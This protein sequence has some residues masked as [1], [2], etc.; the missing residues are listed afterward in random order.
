MHCAGETAR[1]L[2]TVRIA[3][4]GHPDGA[5]VHMPDGPTVHVGFRE[6]QTFPDELAR[7]L[8][9]QGEDQWRL[10][11]HYGDQP[12]LEQRVGV[13]P[14]LLAGWALACYRLQ[15]GWSQ[16]ELA[17]RLS[18]AGC[19]LDQ[20]AVSRLEA[21]ERGLSVDELITAA[22]ELNVSP[23]RLLEGAPLPT[24]PAVT[25]TDTVTVPGSRYRTWLRGSTPLPARKEWSKRTGLP[26]TNAYRQ[27]VADEDWLQ[28]QRHTIELLTRAGQEIINA[29]IQIRD[30]LTDESRTSLAD[31]T[32]HYHSL[33]QQLDQSGYRYPSQRTQPERRGRPRRRRADTGSSG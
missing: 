5:D 4:V 13:R 23:L 6:V 19:R 3:F 28:R 18:A 29:A 10:V 31:A 12:T 11:S 14:S 30:Q 25:V 1:L 27:A 33:L 16:T 2:C 8:L 9:A 20:S 26:W 7:S 17:R 24:Q 32:D 15:R 22:G 21:G